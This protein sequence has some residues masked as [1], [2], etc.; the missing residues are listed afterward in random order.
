MTIAPPILE[1]YPDLNGDQR[2]IVGHVD[3]PLL[4]VAGWLT[5]LDRSVAA[6]LDRRSASPR[7]KLPRIRD[8]RR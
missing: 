8:N 2:E 6:P 4:V 5:E 3:G 1:Q 7:N